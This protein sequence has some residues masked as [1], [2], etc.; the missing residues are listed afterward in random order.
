MTLEDYRRELEYQL[1]DNVMPFWIEKTVD[2]E[3]GGCLHHLDRDGSVISPNKGM[4]V[5]GRFLWLLSWLCRTRGGDDDFLVTS[6]R[7][8]DFIRSHARDS[9]GRWWY[10]L[11]RDGRPRRKRRYFFT[12]VFI[13]LG[14]SSWAAADPGEESRAAAETARRDL[15]RLL[16][17]R[18]T[19]PPKYA[20]G[21]PRMR[22]HADVMI[23]INLYQEF[24]GASGSKKEQR[25]W[26]AEIDLLIDELFRFFVKDSEGVL[27][28]NTGPDGEII[29]TPEGR[30][31]NPGHAVETAWF[32]LDEARFRGDKAPA[33][34]GTSSARAPDKAPAR[35]GAGSARALDEA[36][37]RGDEALVSRALGILSD[38]LERG[39]DEEYGGIRAF[40]DL[41]GRSSLRIEARMKY[42]W[43]HTEAMYAA[44]AAFALTGD[45]LWRRWFSRITDYTLAA[46]PDPEG[47]EWFGYLFPDGSLAN[48]VKGNLWKGP[49][50]IPRSLAKCSSLLGEM[51]AKG[52]N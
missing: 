27:L 25:E 45:P 14:L 16:D 26:S 15:A 38:A 34:P 30:E 22:S 4:W 48:A 47:P 33:R 31:V 12:E 11:T 49:F 1:N 18:D 50:H 44:L 51:A 39:W 2:R 52:L 32:L 13:A 7:V 3:Y 37:F 46:F 23:L 41:R 9:D 35:S 21:L 6:R 42:W 43:P 29:D 19:L 24:R 36:R 10:E 8:F 28:E 20:A 40:T 5:H 17:H